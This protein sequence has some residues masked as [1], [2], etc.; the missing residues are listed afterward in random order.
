MM[1]AAVAGLGV[2]LRSA[3]LT[4]LTLCAM[5]FGFG[6]G[7]YNPHALS[8]TM[9]AAAKGEEIVTSSSLATVR[10]LGTAF[11]ASA[12]AL[13]A[14]IAG[15]QTV[16]GAESVADAL[17]W[18]FVWDVVPLAFAMLSMFRFLQLLARPAAAPAP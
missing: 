3:S 5:V 11:G 16:A 8:K 1:L 10:A 12:S 7:M 15:L 17:T 9:S 14:N 4:Y 6:M 13:I 18:V 2:D